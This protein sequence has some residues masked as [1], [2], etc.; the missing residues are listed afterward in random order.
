MERVRLCEAD[1]DVIVVSLRQARL[2]ILFIGS[3]LPGEGVAI[4]TV[5]RSLH[6]I[7]NSKIGI[8]IIG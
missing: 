7:G 5:V 1:D 2:L 3:E 6:S 8:G 4:T